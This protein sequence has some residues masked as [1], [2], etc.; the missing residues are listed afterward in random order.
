MNLALAILLTFALLGCATTQSSKRL[1]WDA[2]S[3][4]GGGYSIL[5]DGI[6]IGQTDGRTW[7]ISR[8]HTYAVQSLETGETS[9]NF[10][11]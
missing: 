7:P 5:R 10:Y 4:S 1:A 8:G 9:T 3:E 2:G 11:Y 6:A